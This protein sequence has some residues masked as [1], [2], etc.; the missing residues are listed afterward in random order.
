M[1][2]PSSS[3]TAPH[4]ADRGN[5]YQA[6]PW[7]MPNRQDF[8]DFVLRFQHNFILGS[9]LSLTFYTQFSL[10]KAIIAVFHLD[11]NT[12]LL[13]ISVPL[14]LF[15]TLLMLMSYAPAYTLR[16]PM[17]VSGT[18]LGGLAGIWAGAQTFRIALHYG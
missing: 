13:P 14:G 18:Y 10:I 7:S 1:S 12:Y 4:V 9:I 15:W 6:S 17:L 3:T 16:G 11:P 8:T 2:D 5:H